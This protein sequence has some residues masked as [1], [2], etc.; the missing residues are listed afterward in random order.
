MQI[1]TLWM[2]VGM[3]IATRWD[4]KHN[5]VNRAPLSLGSLFGNIVGFYLLLQY[6]Q[7]Y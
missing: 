2:I 5:I 1:L 3:F 7:L 6:G 4:K